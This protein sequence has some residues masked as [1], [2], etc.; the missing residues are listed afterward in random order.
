MPDTRGHRSAYAALG[1]DVTPAQVI[2]FHRAVFGSARMDATATTAPTTSQEPAGGPTEAPGSP[3]AGQAA[4]TPQEGAQPAEQ[5][6]QTEAPKVE[7][8]DDPAKARAE[9]ERLRRENGAARTTAKQQAADEARRALA[10]EIGKALGLVQEQESTDPAELASRVTSLTSGNKAL[11][12]ENAILK[13][14]PKH[15]ADTSALT[16]SRAFLARA[17]ALDPAAADFGAQLDEL[18][19]SALADN[20]KLKAAQVAGASG[21]D[22]AGGS[23]EGRAKPSTLEEAIA[24][25]LGA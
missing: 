3:S 12:I 9:I 4:T 8:W 19:K 16:D 7:A 13:A 10:Q 6:T 5:G 17:E 18:I 14:A 20:P 15:G 23:G 25:K 21:A 22:H 11:A 1:S 24:K 2:A